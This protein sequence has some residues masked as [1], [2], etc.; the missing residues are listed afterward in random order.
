MTARQGSSGWRWPSS[1]VAPRRSR[2]SDGRHQRRPGG[3][4]AIA[5]LGLL[6]L[7]Y[8]REGDADKALDRSDAALTLS[9]SVGLEE[10]WINVDAHTARAGL[11]THAGRLDEARAELDRALELGRRGSGPVETIHALV[12]HGLAAGAAGEDDV[13]RASIAEARLLLTSC[14]SPG[15]VVTTLVDDASARLP[16]TDGPPGTAAV[17]GLQR[18]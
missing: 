1:A 14:A 10:Y 2:P 13:A 17:R 12:A 8:L 3:A 7:A 6:A 15:P 4:T 16:R 11:L 5:C 18:A 9:R